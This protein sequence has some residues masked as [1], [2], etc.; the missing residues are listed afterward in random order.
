MGLRD[1][2]VAIDK[3]AVVVT[4][5]DIGGKLAPVVPIVVFDH[6]PCAE[7]RVVAE[8]HAAAHSVSTMMT[9]ANMNVS[10]AILMC[11][12]Y[13]P[14]SISCLPMMCTYFEGVVDLTVSK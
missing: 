7:N 4:A 3:V 6:E 8:P 13:L 2:P 11:Q 5:D 1:S 10:A 9:L 12:T 14:N